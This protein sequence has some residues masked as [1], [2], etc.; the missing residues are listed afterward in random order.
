MQYYKV[1]GADA[2]GLSIS[3][4]TNVIELGNADFLLARQGGTMMT[5]AGGT[6]DANPLKTFFSMSFA[7]SSGVTSGYNITATGV[8]ASIW[9]ISGLYGNYAGEAFD[10]DPGGDPGY[11]RWDNSAAQ[12]TVSGN[13]YRDEGQTLMG[14]PICDGVTQN[15]RLKVQGAGTYS[16]A[17]N[18][19]T[20]AFSISSIIYNPKDTLTLYLAST[21]GARAVNIAYDPV[22]NITNMH[23][24]Q[25]RVILRHEQG[26]AVGIREMEDDAI[27]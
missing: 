14:A 26:T 24:Y 25:N 23:L 8:S 27:L 19:G 3:G 15:V 4:T 17:C 16:S 10:N 21:T 1:R 22:T 13:V 12:I 11:I 5:V 9:S 18:S 6:I 7:T 20:G 2:N